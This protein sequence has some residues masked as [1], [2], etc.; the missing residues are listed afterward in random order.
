MKTIYNI[1]IIIFAFTFVTGCKKSYDDLYQNT[2]KPTAVPASLLLNG[3]LND[4]IDEPASMYER[5][6]QYFV[7]NYDYY[8]NN[9]YEF[10]EGSNFYSTLNNV[11]RM[12]TEAK[13]AGLP[14]VNVYS[15]LGKFFRA[16]F[17]TKM[18]LQVGDIPMTQALAGL[19]NFTPVYDPQKVVFQQAFLWLD[20]ANS[21]LATLVAANDNNLQGDIFYSNNISKWQKL[22]NTFRLRLLINLSKKTDDP[23]LK[24]PQQ[25]AEIVGNPTI[26][27]LMQ[28]M[29][30]NLQYKY[31]FPTNLYPNNPGNF[32][33]DALRY[34]SSNTYVGL[35]TKLKDP[36]V[37]VTTEPATAL[38]GGGKVATDFSAFKG[39]SPGEDLGT[40]YIKT[41]NGEYS[42]LNRKR[43]YDT[44][45]GEPSIQI[46]YP[47]MLFNIA[48]AINRGWLISGTLGGAEDYYKAGITTSWQFYDI[49]QSGPFAVYFLHPGAS[50]GTYDTYSI[51]VNF[52]EYYNQ[53]LVKYTGDNTAGLEQILNQK[54]LALFRHSGLE[55]YYQYRRT[56]I[57]DFTTGPGTGNSGRIASRFQY[58]GTEKT[59]NTANYQSALQSQYG[60]NDDINGVMWLLK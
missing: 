48:E 44:Y 60:G 47:E 55:S 18:S 23:E 51:D 28:G 9:R 8:G 41:N 30:D 54:Y 35:L 59:A 27:P 7:I 34:N 42:L 37:Y 39:A 25:F 1:L 21:Q 38:V 13:T 53:S 26:Y 20:S 2:N 24:V 32:G 15:A 36:R 50:L 46:G 29:D 14:E 16:Y 4:M 10:G 12:E 57:P 40:M 19:Q 11:I 52:S 49:P 33:F 58:S 5:W 45:T 56:G 31:V 17:F 22:V 3:V 43:Y 6:S